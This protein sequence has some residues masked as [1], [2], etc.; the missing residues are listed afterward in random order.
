MHRE[1]SLRRLKP[2]EHRQLRDHES[3]QAETRQFQW[4]PESH[5]FPIVWLQ[6]AHRECQ[7]YRRALYQVHKRI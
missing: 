3:N 4:T 5:V 2:I 1:A 6:H 7:I